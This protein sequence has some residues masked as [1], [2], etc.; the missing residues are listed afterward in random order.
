PE[1]EFVNNL[2]TIVNTLRENGTEVII[3]TYYKMISELM[4][5]HRAA[6]FVRYMN[7]V[8]VLAGKLDCHVVDQYALFDKIDRNY[9]VFNLMRDPMHTNENGNMLIGLNLCRYFDVDF[10]KIGW[11]DALLPMQQLLNRTLNS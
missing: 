10:E 5:T 8:R 4:Q 2:T 9:R 7:A 11:R 1:D 3:Q 6:F